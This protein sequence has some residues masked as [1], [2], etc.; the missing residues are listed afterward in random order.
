MIVVYRE[1]D[2]DFHRAIYSPRTRQLHSEGLHWMLAGRYDLL[3]GLQMARLWPW[4]PSPTGCQSDQA[5]GQ[6][7]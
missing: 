2:F 1:I 5:C 3:P 4:L 7:R 6:A